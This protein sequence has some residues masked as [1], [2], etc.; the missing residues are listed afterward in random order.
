M[1]R[2]RCVRR[3]SVAPVSRSDPSTSVHDSNGRLL[4]TITLVRSYAVEMTSNKSSAL[5]L[6]A[7]T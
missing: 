6:D 4:V 3:S 1:I 7:G 5:T 2:H